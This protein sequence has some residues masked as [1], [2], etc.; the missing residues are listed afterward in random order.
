[1]DL[2]RTVWR[3]SSC[4][5]DT[6][7]VQVALVGATWRKSSHSA[8]TNCVEVALAGAVWNKASS[9]ANAGNCVEVVRDLPGQ[10]G[11]V[12]IRDSKNPGGPSLIITATAWRRFTAD[13]R[14]TGLGAA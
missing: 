7:C 14:S 4:S 6:N 11:I 9:S 1:M 3:A 8:D 13:L 12:A 5:A 10:P 2:T